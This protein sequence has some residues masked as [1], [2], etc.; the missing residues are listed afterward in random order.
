MSGS[1]RA[2]NATRPVIDFA[3]EHLRAR[4]VEARILDLVELPGD[5]LHAGMYEASLAHAYL[6]EAERVLKGA[7][8]WVLAFPEYN[9]SFPGALKLFF[10]ALS[11]RDYK[12]LFGGRVAGLI[13]TASGRQGNLRGLD[14]FTA[15]LNHMGTTVMPKSLPVSLIE[16]HLDTERAFVGEDATEQVGKYLDRFLAYAPRRL[17]AEA[18]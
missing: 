10:D 13:G 12:G 4:G 9:G 2:G 14:H 16:Q 6:D 3:A 17:A 1:N 15:V 8:R 7:D 11:V 18:A 5:V